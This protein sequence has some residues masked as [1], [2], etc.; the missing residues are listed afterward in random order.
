MAHLQELL[1]LE[2]AGWRALSSSGDAATAFY[3]EVLA[4]Q[5]VMLLPGGLWITD[6]QQAIRSMGGAPWDAH[7]L[8][9]ERVDALTDTC[10]IV[11]YRA[12]ARRGDLEYRAL[13]SST[14]V[15]DGGRWRLAV[16]QQT[17]A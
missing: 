3:G 6:R 12:S 15:A 16:H 1:E 4:P 5:V 2:R 11:S 13:M 8:A 7:Q 10:A 14:Y 17:P 9:D